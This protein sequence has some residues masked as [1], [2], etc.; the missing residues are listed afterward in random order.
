M[1]R[2]EIGLVRAICVKVRSLP[3]DWY[4]DSHSCQARSSSQRKELFKLV[5]IRKNKSPCQLLLDMKVR[6]GSTY[7]MLNRAEENKDVCNILISFIH[8]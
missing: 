5:Q 3:H 7:V 1:D 8:S 2:D 4:I 6:W